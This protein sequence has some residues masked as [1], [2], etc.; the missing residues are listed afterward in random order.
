MEIQT[1][2]MLLIV[3]HVLPAVFWVG[4]TFVLARMGG[5]GAE[6]LTKSQLIAAVIV[7][8]SGLGL[9]S[10]THP[11]RAGFGPA[12]Q[13]LA[14]GAICALAALAIQSIFVLPSVRA[15]ATPGA[16]T[17]NGTR[18]RIAIAERVAA[19][20]LATTV[21]CMVIARYV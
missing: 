11:F 18:M 16:V 10:Q 3:L 13:V 21:I 8:A 2:L 20:L 14:T 19:A 9:W 4:S 1:V 7:V 15:L 5:L 6:R 12:E 17:S